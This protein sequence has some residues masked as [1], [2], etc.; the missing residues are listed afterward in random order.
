MSAS[1]PAFRFPLRGGNHFVLHVDGGRFFPAMLAAIDG[2]RH[3]AA[4][5]MYLFESGRVADRFIRALVAAA[6]RGVAVYVLLDHYG[7]LALRENDRAQLIAG[8]VRLAYYNPLQFTLWRRVFYRDHRK[9]LIADGVV[10]FVG[11]AGVTDE[12][13]PASMPSGRHWRE[14]MIEVRGAVVRDWIELFGEVWQRSAGVVLS[15]ALA[16][17]I[18]GT[19][20]G[21]VVSNHARS[22]WEVNRSLLKRIRAAKQR[23][24]LATAYFVPSWKLRR[25][26]RGAAR[27]GVDVRLLLPGPHSDHPGVRHAGRRRYG[28]LL[29]HGA[30]VFEYQPR[31][32]HQKVF[33]CDEWVS[34]GSSN[35]DRWGQRWNLEANQEVED[36][37]FAQRAHD[38]L[39]AD[40]A[41]AVEMTYES[42]RKRSWYR[43]ALEWFW[44]RVDRLLERMER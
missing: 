5:E 36:A 40:F 2:A 35:V 8:G 19:Q 20:R 6:R 44:G 14:T 37:D 27:A 22:L 25:A 29:R 23:V 13:D 31:F 26:L 38:M 42:W 17:E 4:L 11:G 12:F 21:R 28:G 30:R 9:L 7:S 3:F 32:M 34:I 1:R 24:W 16:P 15:L 43:R 39:E 10:A 18:A 33:L 41:A